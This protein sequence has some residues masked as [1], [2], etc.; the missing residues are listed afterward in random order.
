M[1]TV[2]EDLGVQ[3]TASGLDCRLI[4]TQRRAQ[5]VGEMSEECKFK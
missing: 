4:L 5:T 1:D 2:Q 3:V